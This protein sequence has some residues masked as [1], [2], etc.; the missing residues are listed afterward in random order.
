MIR[1]IY[2]QFVALLLSIGM[3]SGH[4]YDGES[5]RWRVLRTAVLERDSYRCRE[6]GAKAN[7]GGMWLECHHQR[8]VADGGSYRPWNLVSLC[9]D[10][11]R[12]RHG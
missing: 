1:R 7:Y 3:K 2:W 9:R 12:A 10:C 5:F 11:H 8:R 4:R 6:C